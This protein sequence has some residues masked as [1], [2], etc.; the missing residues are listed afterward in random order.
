[1]RE[2]DTLIICGFTAHMCVE[3][4]VRDAFH[5]EYKVIIDNEACA[6]CDFPFVGAGESSL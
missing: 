1:M 4:T 5:Q 3:S 6:T 2:I